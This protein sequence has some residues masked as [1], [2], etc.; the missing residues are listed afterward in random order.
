MAHHCHSLLDC[1]DVRGLLFRS[2]TVYGRIKESSVYY[3]TTDI[4]AYDAG[5]WL[6][7]NYPGNTTVVV[8]EIPGFWFSKLFRKKR[9]CTN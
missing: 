5:V 8:T 2:D 9:D 4:K 3:S 1:I 7:Q 6:S